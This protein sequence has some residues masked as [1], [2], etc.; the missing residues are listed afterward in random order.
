MSYDHAMCLADV[1]REEGFRPSAYQDH[2]GFWTIGYGVCID[3]RKGCGITQGEAAFLI[4]N[5][6]DRIRGELDIAIP[7]W[8][9]LSAERCSALMSM[10][11][12]MGVRGLLGFHKMLD[13]MEAGEFDKAADEALDS[14][15]ADQTP[16]RA[17]RVSELIRN[18]E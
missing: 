6:L 7:W 1:I 10:A 2:L 14:T 5:R 15:W 12:Q 17:K 16:A 8:R 13:H 3:A 11:Y 4:E 18:G 9:E